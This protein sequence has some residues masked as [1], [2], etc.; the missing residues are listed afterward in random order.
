MVCKGD[1]PTRSKIRIIE[2]IMEQVYELRY[3]ENEILHYRKVDVGSKIFQVSQNHGTD[4]QNDRNHQYV[5]RNQTG[6]KKTPFLVPM[7]SYH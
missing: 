5:K 6:G 7:I 2:K 1:Q 4:V 3:L